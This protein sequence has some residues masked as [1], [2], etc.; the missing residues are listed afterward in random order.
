MAAPVRIRDS[1]K[2]NLEKVQFL[3][4]DDS[5]QSLDIMAQVVSGF[6][7]K[8]AIKCSSAREAREVIMKQPLDI[9]LTDAHMPE[10]DGYTLII[11]VR[12]EGPEPNR[13]VPII[14]VT[15]HTPQSMVHRARDCGAHFVV[16]KPLTPRVLLE[17]IFWSAREDR[18]FIECDTY[19][20]PDRRFQR[21]GPPPGTEGR[22][23]DDLK[24]QLGDAAEP[25]L[26]Q[27][28]IDAM[29]K[30]AKVTL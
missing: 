15:G 27:A 7:A 10:Q 4:V 13:F 16:A 14:L 21:L 2:I 30:P 20:G 22:R 9:I 26:T 5:P 8:G 17:R 29:M 19:V 1:D 6:G 23:A 24:G 18:K 3:L 28:D 12:R 25:N 11:W